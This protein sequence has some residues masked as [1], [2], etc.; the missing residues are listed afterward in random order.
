[1]NL[2]EL[3]EYLTPTLREALCLGIERHGPAPLRWLETAALL[4]PP[5]DFDMVWYGSGLD[6]SAA[7]SVLD[8]A[9]KHRWII[10]A[11]SAGYRLGHDLL[12]HA[13]QAQLR[14]ERAIRLHRK[15]AQHLSA[16]GGH[17]ADLARHLEAAGDP[18][19]AYP[20]WREA[21][22]QA[23]RHW[24]HDEALAFLERAV[25]CTA[26][27]ILQLEGQFQRCVHH[28]ALNDLE[29]WGRELDTVETV[30]TSHADDPAFQ[31]HG[32]EA[33]LKCVRQRAHLL[34]RA[35]RVDEALV[36]SD[37]WTADDLSE[38]KIALLHDRGAILH[39]LGRPHQAAQLLELLL[40]RLEPGQLKAKANLHNALALAV[41]DAGRLKEGFE[42]AEQAIAL[43]GELHSTGEPYMKEGLACAY[44]NQASLYKQLGDDQAQLQALE[45][46]VQHAAEASNVYI[47]R[48]CLEVMCEAAEKL[49]QWALGIEHATKGLELCEEALDV[50]G[51]ELFNEWIRRFRELRPVRGDEGRPGGL[52]PPVNVS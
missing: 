30:L 23:A 2:E 20:Q 3:E 47:Q 35:G 31:P 27:P 46:A 8:L 5:F 28:K 9:L 29:A 39:S 44:G 15:L 18:R 7:L 50:W 10:A 32:A 21:A 42:H 19:A 24:A 6:E 14:P 52:R 13:L 43:F 17:V 38:E 11:E 25:A 16:S 40:G 12:R 49:G 48:Q 51:T 36:L 26:D 22:R 34:L 4:T 33:W 45:V 41:A 1:M 37:G